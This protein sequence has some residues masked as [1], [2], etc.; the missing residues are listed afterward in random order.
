M[1]NGVVSGARD[2]TCDDPQGGLLAPFLYLCNSN[3]ME[4]SV[5]SKLLLYA[6]DSVLLASHRDPNI[7]SKKLKSDLISCDQWFSE[8]K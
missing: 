1:I 6:D 8:N 5:D 2:I 7:V 3:D 4:I